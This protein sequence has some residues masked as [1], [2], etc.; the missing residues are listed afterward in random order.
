MPDGRR[1][2]VLTHP[3][4]LAAFSYKNAT[5]PIHRG[6]FLTRSVAGRALKSPPFAVAFDETE[7]SPGMTMREKVVKLTQAETCQGCHAVINPLGFSLEWF[8]AVGRFRTHEQGRPIEATSEY[9]TDE[10]TPVQLA[11]PRDVA[12]F[13]IGNEQ[14]TQR[15][16]EQLFHHVMKQPVMAFGPDALPRLRES[17]VAS[18][19]NLQ[20]LLIEIAVRGA[21]RGLDTA[22]AHQ[23][24]NSPRP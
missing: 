16:V 23:S 22:L 13:A 3:Y 21:R 17:F 1:A 14:A 15:F 10:G 4:V 9:F 5:S 18:D 20:Q 24:P 12:E 6:V 7:F 11:T 2:G 8:D 19:Y